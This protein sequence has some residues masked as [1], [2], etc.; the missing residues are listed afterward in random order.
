M[1]YGAKYKLGEWDIRT[2]SAVQR[3]LWTNYD[4]YHVQDA[5]QTGVI[6][7]F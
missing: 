2:Q 4:L 3:F 5:A 6:R 1:D 7:S